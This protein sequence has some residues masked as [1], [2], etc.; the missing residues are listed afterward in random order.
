MT[1]LKIKLSFAP[2]NEE[3]DAENISVE[4]PPANKKPSSKKP[5]PKKVLEIHE[6]PK[7]WGLRWVL[8]PN[9]FDIPSEI[10]LRK[11]VPLDN[12][13]EEAPEPPR[14]YK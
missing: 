5:L 14:I 11:W 1:D 6:R 7:R 13:E 4:K 9:V 2:E 12:I 10:W 8:Y 3:N